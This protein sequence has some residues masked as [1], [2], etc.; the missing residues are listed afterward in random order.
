MSYAMTPT[1]TPAPELTSSELASITLLQDM[2]TY[3][4]PARSE[5]EAAWVEQFID[6]LAQ[7]EHV[8]EHGIDAAG[9]RWLIVG[10]PGGTMFTS[11]TDS[12]HRIEGRQ[13]IAMKDGII[14]LA[15]GETANC[16]G[17]DDAAGCWVLMELIRAGTPGL[18]VF[19][20]AEE[21]GGVGSRY[22]ADH[23][24]E[25]VA[26][27]ER[28]ISFDRKGTAS[29]ITHQ[30]WG[31]C[32]SNE[33]ADALSE[34]LCGDVLMYSPDDS[35][36]FTDS[37]NFVDLIPE[38]TNISVGYYNEHQAI[39]RL[40]VHHLV[41]LARALIGVDWSTLPTA[42]DPYAAVESDWEY[43]NPINWRGRGGSFGHQGRSLSDLDA[44]EIEAM[45]FDDLLDL[46]DNTD[47]VEVTD[48]LMDLAYKV[49]RSQNH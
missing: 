25:I 48:V 11:H 16:L 27:I 17:A 45:T 29:I 1:Q 41:H 37:A 39:E 36:V 38:C 44:H 6:P 7:C 49:R 19:F 13:K 18:Y 28:C 20:R 40:D 23:T 15:P 21:V 5:T 4:R 12:V 31:R 3:K 8:T 2:L 14:H 30:G 43:D 35:G 32:C 26:G 33:F 42:R 24:P 22:M 10:E 46:V 34:R 9:N 47:P